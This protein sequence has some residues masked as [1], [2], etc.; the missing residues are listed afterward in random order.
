MQVVCIKFLQDEGCV[1]DVTLCMWEI[2]KN[3]GSSNRQQGQMNFFHCY[4]LHQLYLG[5]LAAVDLP[6][7]ECRFQCYLRI[8][9]K[10][11]ILDTSTL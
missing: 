2:Y 4:V 8:E 6:L 11:L 3:R 7:V 9:K 5:D 10:R 1:V